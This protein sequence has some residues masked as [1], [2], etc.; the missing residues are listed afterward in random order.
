MRGKLEMTL[1]LLEGLDEK[2][3]SLVL[4]HPG[5]MEL[6]IKQ[7]GGV[8]VRLNHLVGYFIPVKHV[9][10]LLPEDVK[11][12]MELLHYLLDDKDKEFM[13]TPIKGGYK[14]YEQGDIIYTS[15]PRYLGKLKF[16]SIR[17][18]LLI[19]L[20]SLINEEVR[21]LLRTLK[22]SNLK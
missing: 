4:Y 16:Y 10:I 14:I 9:C 1:R 18:R 19:K 17:N 8:T 22:P 3:T 7:H 5:T 21:L 15:R 20:N 13:V 11:Y 6:V 2:R 12:I